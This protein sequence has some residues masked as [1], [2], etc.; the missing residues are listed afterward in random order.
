M[1]NAL[2]IL[3]MFV[4]LIFEDFEHFENRKK[5]NLNKTCYCRSIKKGYNES[6]RI[7]LY[8]SIARA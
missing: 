5:C 3:L 2:R 6:K 7:Y 1:S 8:N 4:K